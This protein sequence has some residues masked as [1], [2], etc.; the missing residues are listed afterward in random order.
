MDL[1]DTYELL[2]VLEKLEPINMFWTNR[3]FGEEHRSEKEEIYFDKIAH[4]RKLA[5]FV[6]PV[7][8]GQVM[9]ESGFSTNVFKPA[10]IKP[11][12]VVDP[13]QLSTRRVGEGFGGTLTMAQREDAMIVEKL[14][15]QYEAIQRRWEWMSANA[16]INGAVTVSG[17]GYESK[18]VNFGRSVDNE[19]TLTG[20]D[21]F[22]APTTSD[23]EALF[24]S[25]S[26]IAFDKTGYPIVDWVMSR[27]TFQLFKK[28]AAVK[29]K[30]DADRTDTSNIISTD[31]LNGSEI[32]TRRG[33][34]GEFNIWTYRDFYTD[35]GTKQ[36]YLPDNV[37]IG[38]GSLE[39][40]SG[41]R[42]F[43]AI[44]DKRAGY[45]TLPIFSKM[46]DQEDPSATFMMS[47]S[48]PLMVPRRIDATFKVTV[49]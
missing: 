13:T 1:Y 4:E 17:E 9:H 20:G 49:A 16:I 7:A 28:I 43:G 41:V 37:V 21:K 2:G 11:K 23:P 38:L 44:K 36:F 6:S 45:Q 48:A 19:V 35:G 3:C 15:K 27:N 14:Q 22:D 34:L 24:E 26:Q 47:Q 33:S 18:V 10:Y 46:W 31:A 5:P 39:A 25:F 40:I 30:F 42:C 8:E 29:D 32:A 12:G